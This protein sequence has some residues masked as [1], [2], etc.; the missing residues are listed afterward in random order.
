MDKNEAKQVLSRELE[1]YRA[2]SYDEL[3]NCIGDSIAYE[4]SGAS[5][6]M[7]QL[8]ITVLWDSRPDGDVRVIASVDDGGWSAFT[9]LSGDFIK[10]PA[11]DS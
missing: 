5:G 7:Y 9:P 4:T 3:V 11:G 6:A 1:S 10:N 8:E 2:R